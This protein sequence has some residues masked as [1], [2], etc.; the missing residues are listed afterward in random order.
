MA[1]TPLRLHGPALVSNVAATKYTV[2]AGRRTI[3]RH[4]R[5]A[6]TAAGAATLTLSIGADAAGTRVY[7]VFSIAASSI[8]DRWV[9]FVLAAAEI[10]AGLSGTNNVL[11]LTINGDEQ[12]V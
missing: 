10:I 1:G 9:Y 2:P 8:E 12:I 3:V 5:V 7:E 6:N 11:T 4:I